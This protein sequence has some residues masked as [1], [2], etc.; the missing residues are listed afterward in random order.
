MTTANT[1]ITRRSRTDCLCHQSSIRLIFSGP[2]INISRPPIKKRIPNANITQN[3]LHSR[4]PTKKTTAK[5]NLIS[6]AKYIRLPCLKNSISHFI[7]PGF[8]K[9]KIPIRMKTIP[10]FYS[11]IPYQFDIIITPKYYLK[12]DI[13]EFSANLYISRI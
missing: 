3:C 1:A 6:P 10:M 7:T 11:M 5:A 4:A 13:D 2:S 8:R 9:Y 12:R